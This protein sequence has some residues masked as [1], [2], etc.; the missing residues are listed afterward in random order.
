MLFGSALVKNR[1]LGHTVP[2][3]RIT[4]LPGLTV[5]LSL[6]TI[7]RL[8]VRLLIVALLRL[9]I[10]LLIVALLRLA[11][12][13]LRIALPGK[14]PQQLVLIALSGLLIELI[15]ISVQ[16]NTPIN[17]YKKAEDSVLG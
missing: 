7:L 10:G 4:V 6:I 15:I 16:A 12:R 8:A 14:L 13:L 2:V 3:L 5:R 9:A 17:G 1:C 11:V